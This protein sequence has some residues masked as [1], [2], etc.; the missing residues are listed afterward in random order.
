MACEVDSDMG[1]R[2]PFGTHI[3]DIFVGPYNNVFQKLESIQP[4]KPETILTLHKNKMDEINDHYQK[5]P[6]AVWWDTEM[7]INSENSQLLMFSLYLSSI[8]YHWNTI[9]RKLTKFISHV[10][11]FNIM[12]RLANIRQMDRF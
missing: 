9:D 7:V 8:V 2:T 6:A 1:V 5:V 11:H 10:N 12:I 3:P 4:V